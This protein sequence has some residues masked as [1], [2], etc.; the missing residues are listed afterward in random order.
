MAKALSI[1][2]GASGTVRDYIS[3]TK[4]RLSGFVLFTCAAGLWLAPGKIAITPML[5]TLFLTALLVG[6]ANAFNCLLERDT[7]ALMQRTRTRA[8]PDGRLEPKN[9]FWF[10]LVT[11]TVSFVGLFF[12]ANT[13]TALAGLLAL[14]IYVGCY[15]PM[16][17]K[18]TLA[19]Y[20][21]AIPGAMPPLMGWTAISNRLDAGALWLFALLFFWQIPH[22][23]AISLYLRKDY[24][25]ARLKVF[26]TVYGE[27]TTIIAALLSS[28]LLLLVSLVPVS[29]GLASVEYGLLAMSVGCLQV[30]VAAVGLSEKRSQGWPRLLFFST[31]FN[32]SCL[33][34][35]VLIGKM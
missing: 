28:I 31:L 25:R 3:L 9:A 26:S 24:E 32:L 16:K 11:G 2:M 14:L 29:I 17:R 30:I 23:L 20:V 10:A 21:G 5:G 22:F 8:L 13:L 18:T 19:L 15:T 35:G 7:D 4:P 12:T 27:R 33:F 6:S 1:S 34:I